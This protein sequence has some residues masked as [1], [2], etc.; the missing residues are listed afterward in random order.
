MTPE[1]WAALSEDQR[2]AALTQYYVTGK[3]R[4]QADFQKRGG[5]PNTYMPDLSAAGSNTYFY[6]RENN[7][8]SNPELLR[9]A[10][11]P[12]QRTQIAPGTQPS[13]TADFASG[14]NNAPMQQV[15]AAQRTDTPVP[16]TQPGSSTL[17]PQVV[18]ADTGDVANGPP[19]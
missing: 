3:E 17:P 9:N 13:R 2:A 15:S 18:A 4:M 8:V 11:S 6:Q 19:Q 5:D 14:M 7:A 12:D 10:L 16:P 1:R